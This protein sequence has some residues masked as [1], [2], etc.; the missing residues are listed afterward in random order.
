MQSWIQVYQ[1]ISVNVV[2]YKVKNEV[3]IKFDIIVVSLLHYDRT[4]KQYI[5]LKINVHRY[6]NIEIPKLI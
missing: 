1:K 6:V 2:L 3:K 5:Y 4:C